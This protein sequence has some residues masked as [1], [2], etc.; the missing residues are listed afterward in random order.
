MKIL[1]LA[2]SVCSFAS[3]A[4]GADLVLPSKIEAVNVHLEGAE[5]TRV[6]HYRLQAGETSIVLR[7]IA[8]NLIDESSLR[9]SGLEANGISIRA[10]STR[11]DSAGASF[12]SQAQAL[13]EE[14]EQLQ[15]RLD[16]LA[17]KE[18]MIR[19]LA[20][21][22][23]TL[24][25]GASGSSA[26]ADFWPSIWTKVA[27]GLED[28]E[29]RLHDTQKRLAEV[30]LA[31]QKASD[32]ASGQSAQTSSVILDVFAEH[33]AEADLTLVYQVYGA[34]WQPIYDARL[35]TALQ[36]ARLGLSRRARVQQST[37][38]DWTNVPLKLSTARLSAAT[39]APILRETSDATGGSRQIASFI[40]D[41]SS[42]EPYNVTLQVPGRVSVA[43]GAAAKLYDIGSST[44]NADLFVRSA[45][46]ADRRA[47][48][49]ARF[50]SQ[51]TIPL[52]PGQIQLYR[53]GSF[54]GRAILQGAMLGDPVTIGFGADDLVSVERTDMKRRE[55][56]TTVENGIA[57]VERVF[58]TVV[59]NRHPFPIDVEIDDREPAF[60]NV[61][62]V[63]T[64]LPTI[65]QPTARRVDGHRG[66]LAWTY[67]Y[68]PG[69]ARTMTLAW[70]VR[71]PAKLGPIQG[72]DD[73]QVFRFSGGADF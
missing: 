35:Q 62:I 60:N 67:D 18:R 22:Q 30:N 68:A 39:T 34:G 33:A 31:A 53:D 7:G 40:A 1:I 43:S 52:M 29:H 37:G 4:F 49:Q 27:D 6:A 16:A 36:P 61:A 24:A 19:N 44:M 32:T 10:V 65:T 46:I 69:E 2:L 71:W 56:N 9:V 41:A 11:R 57:S 66:V 25:V 51:D 13:H 50:V 45:P 23:P 12:A 26:S 47:Y 3:S 58:K 21:T 20:N 42:A 63:L 48:L 70:R 15:L 73:T 38:E 72:S 28:T 64:E 17:I 14:A 59:T 8:P 5:V 55:R 54:V